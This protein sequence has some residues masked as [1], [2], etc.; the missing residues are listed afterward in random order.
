MTDNHEKGISRDFFAPKNNAN[1]K[2]YRKKNS[3][4]SFDGGVS[5][6]KAAESDVETRLLCAKFGT[7]TFCI[8]WTLRWTMEYSWNVVFVFDIS[9]YQVVKLTARDEQ[10][11][12][13]EDM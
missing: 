8:E 12:T 1:K 5:A 13:G 6:I 4:P 7:G 11:I 3:D 10:C 2:N 9:L